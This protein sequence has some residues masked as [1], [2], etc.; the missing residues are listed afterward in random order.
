MKETQVIRNYIYDVDGQNLNFDVK[1][2]IESKIV[3]SEDTPDNFKILS[4]SSNVLL[5]GRL[6][7]IVVFDISK[8]F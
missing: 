6:L 2:L 4:L 8:D 7:V 5:D 3:T 1:N